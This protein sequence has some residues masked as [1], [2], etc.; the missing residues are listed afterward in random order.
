MQYHLTSLKFKPQNHWS[1]WDLTFMMYKSSWKLILIHFCCSQWALGFVIDHA[2]ICK[3]LRDEAFTW[4]PRRLSFWLKSDLFRQIWP[5][6]TVYVLKNFIILMV[7]SS[8]DINLCFCNKPQWQ[9]L[10]LVSGYAGVHTDGFQHGVSTQIS[11]NLGK[12]FLCISCWRK[13]TVTRVLARGFVD[14][15]SFFSQ[16]LEFIFWTVLIFI[17]INPMWS[18]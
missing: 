17:S 10:L 9:M 6:W 12:T 2:S 16:I 18:K 5:I 14:L 11:I 7:L 4:W 15:L 1:S 3:L 8:S 13:F